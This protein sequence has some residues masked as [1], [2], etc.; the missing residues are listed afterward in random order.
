MEQISGS[1]SSLLVKYPNLQQLA[2]R[3]FITYLKS[4]HTKS[5]KEVFDV[6]KLPIEEFAASLGLP[7]TPRI[8]FISKK[9]GKAEPTETTPRVKNDLEDGSEIVQRKIHKKI[10]SKIEDEDDILVP[11]ETSAE[12]DANGV[13]E[14]VNSS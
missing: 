9:K 4:L 8:R 12:V 2:K 1:L 10:N 14:Y 7:M 11:K 13:S 3:A 5:D 6:S